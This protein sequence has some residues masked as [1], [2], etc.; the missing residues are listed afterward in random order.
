MNASKAPQRIG[1]RRLGWQE[2]VPRFPTSMVE[3]IG[4]E[5]A[6]E[7]FPTTAIWREVKRLYRS[8][9]HPAI[10]LHIRHRD[11]VVMDRT[12]GHLDNAPGGPTGEVVTPDSLFSLFS[13]SKIVTAALV[14]AMVEDGLLD[15]SKPVVHYLPR[16][17]RHGKERITIR[18]LLQHTAGIPDMPR[19]DDLEGSLDRGQIDLEML[20]DL[21]PLT[22]PGTWVAY[23]SLTAWFLLQRIL[24]DLTGTDLRTLL[25]RRLLDPAGI[26]PMSYGVP[27]DRM[28]EVAR[29]AV[30]GPPVPGLM[31]RIFER[32]IGLDLRSAIALTNQAGFLTNILPSGN[33]I[34]T[35]RATTDFMQLLLNEG[36]LHGQQVLRPESVRRM[37]TDLTRAQLDGT[38]G[39]PMRYGLGVMMGGNRFSLFGLGT[40]GAYGHLGLSNVVV[41]ADP[42]RELAVSFLNTGKPLMAPGMVQWY[43]VLQHI[44]ARV[45]RTRPPSRP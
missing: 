31:D 39:F 30:T 7:G 45:P 42:S 14:Q 35:P 27:R 8:G 26:T 6:A 5:E 25:H 11:R 4:Q 13:A 12:I 37:T 2:V 34:A 15:L 21:K 44:V 23:H 33:V 41:Y 10:A 38:F 9:L 17:G 36:T 28:H 19:V 3:R 20:F 32:N 16:F 29:H 18:Q 1:R 40:R 24:E 43:A 22:P